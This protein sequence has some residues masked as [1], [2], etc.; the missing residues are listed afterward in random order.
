[1]SMSYGPGTEVINLKEA[2]EYIISEVRTYQDKMGVMVNLGHRETLGRNR[3]T[4]YQDVRVD[5]MAAQY[6]NDSTDIFNPAALSVSPTQATPHMSYVMYAL[7][8][9]VKDRL[10]TGLAQRYGEQAAMA[11]SRLKDR[12][13]LVTFQSATDSLGADGENLTVGKFQAARDLIEESPDQNFGGPP[14]AVFHPWALYPLRVALTGSSFIGTNNDA[15]IPEGM[16]Q[17]IIKTGKVEVLDGMTVF[18]DRHM[19][20][21]SNN[22]V[23]GAIFVPMGIWMVKGRSD[24][25][26]TEHKTTGGGTDYIFTFSEYTWTIPQYKNI[27]WIVRVIAEAAK[28]TG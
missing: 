25:G 6:M 10:T 27:R 4:T 22:T 14:V 16:S 1:M 17:D 28:P 26:E 7:H 21:A 11:H 20:R 8:W 9:K 2:E 19:S 24:W 12:E 13:G 15:Y 23:I 5:P 18:N 3:G